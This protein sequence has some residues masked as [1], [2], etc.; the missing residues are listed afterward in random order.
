MNVMNYM[1]KLAALSLALA[2][3]VGMSSVKASASDP[4]THGD[5]SPTVNLSMAGSQSRAL[6]KV[7]LT[8]WT[9]QP[10]VIPGG[11]PWDVVLVNV[12]AI[13]N[14]GPLCEMLFQIENA[15]G[16]PS[17]FADVGDIPWYPQARGCQGTP[18]WQTFAEW[19]V[20]KGG[21]HTYEKRVLLCGEAGKSLS[22]LLF[23]P[24]KKAWGVP[25][26]CL[27]TVGNADIEDADLTESEPELDEA[28]RWAREQK[29]A[30]KSH[31]KLFW[32]PND[33]QQAAETS[34]SET[35]E[36]AC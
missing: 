28:Y 20:R 7:T 24:R 34:S 23:L 36:T 14:M 9:L 35:R 32:P 29:L 3:A 2:T 6:A 5:L 18:G 22:S 31:A 33:Q 15:N 13:P 12:P 10:L 17:A 19:W 8:D 26:R 4:N 11:C 16:V 25:A 27:I 1:K 21:K 30:Y